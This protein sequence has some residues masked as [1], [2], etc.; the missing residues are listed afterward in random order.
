MSTAIGV[1]RAGVCLCMDRE[2][3]SRRQVPEDLE[4]I[5]EKSVR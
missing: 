1:G 2:C 5:I 4:V 3:F